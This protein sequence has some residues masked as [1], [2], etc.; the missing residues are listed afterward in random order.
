MVIMSLDITLKTAEGKPF[1]AQIYEQFR[2][3]IQRNELHDGDKVP[4]MREV[5]THCGVSLG[6]V[7]QA[8]NTLTT[9]G[10][11]R[12]H[13]GRG[14]Y[15]VGAQ[16]RRASVALVLPGLDFEQMP[17]IIRGVK[18]GLGQS[19][20]RMI[21]QAAD[22][23]YDHEA[24]LFENLSASFVSGAIIYPPPLNSYVEP[25]RNLRRRGLPF[26][27]VDT[28]LESLDVDSVTTDRL[29]VGR[30]AIRYLL[31][32]GHR[33]IGIVDHTGDAPSHVEIREGADEVLRQYG[34]TFEAL[35]RVA[36]SAD[37]MDADK[38]WANG[39]A[40]VEKLLKAHPDLTAV[41]GMNDNIAMGVFL[42]A[43]AAG[44]K[45]PDDLS[46]L[47]IGD[48]RSFAVSDPPVTAVDQPH[49]EMGKLATQRLQDILNGTA[50][51]T[52]HVR[53]KPQVIERHSIKTLIP[54]LALKTA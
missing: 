22:C 32:R 1:V 42:G 43:R 24:D 49:E 33:R 20:A 17:K 35:P 11:L 50:K 26:V 38:P 29:E 46:V 6:I 3:K 5:A 2:E 9:E 13:P 23:D 52:E 15:V 48:L 27:L 31:E 53:L 45:V 19:S 12:S 7:K 37:Q 10:Y 25:L 30:L 54:G 44:R 16:A 14:L 21:V 36:I 40:G 18:A 39:M 8:F 28:Q 41:I 47:A 51:G 4:S 34:L